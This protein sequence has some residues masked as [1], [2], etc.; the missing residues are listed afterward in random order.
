MKHI[1]KKLIFISLLCL[2]LSLYPSGAWAQID[3]LF[4]FAAPD[5]A[6]IQQGHAD[7]PIYLR[8]ATKA[9][10]TVTVDMP[11]NSSFTPITQNVGAN[12]VGTVDLTP[13][14]DQIETRPFG[15]VLNTG[16]R[17]RSTTPISV[18]YE[19]LA[20][21][22]PPNQNFP[23]NPEIFFLKGRNALGTSFYI[24]SQNF[25]SNSF[26]SNG[27]DVSIVATEDNTVVT[28][29]MRAE[30]VGSPNYQPNQNYSVTLNRGQTF[31]IREVSGNA[32]F[33][34]GGSRI[35]ATKPIAV[36]SSDDS[37]DRNG[38]Q[39]LIGDQIFPVNF[40]GKEYIVP[41]FLPTTGQDRIYVVPTVNNT[42]INLNGVNL[43]IFTAGQMQQIQPSTATS[44]I[45]ANQPIYV[46][47]LTGYPGFGSGIESASAIVPPLE[48]CT[49]TNEVKFFK[50]TATNEDFNVIVLVRDVAKGSFTVNGSTTTLQASDFTI[51]PNTGN[52]WAY[53]IKNLQT[54]APNAN[55]TIANSH[56]QGLFH[57][58]ILN[59]YKNNANNIV[60]ASY[61]FFSNISS[62]DITGILGP[63]R[64]FCDG[65]SVVLD[66]GPGRTSYQWYKDNVL[67]PGATNQTLT[68][69]QAGTYRVDVV[70]AGC[71]SSDEVKLSVTPLP[72]VD[73]GA[74]RTICQGQSTTLDA[75]AGAGR[76]F[77]WFLLPNTTTVI[78]TN[79]TLT[80][81]QAGTYRVEVTQNNCS[82]TDDIVI[83]VQPL[84]TINLGPNQTICPNSSTT[85]DAGAGTG[86]TYKWYRLPNTTDVI[87][88]NRTLT[89]TQAGTYRVEV[90]QNN[91]SNTAEI[92][93]NIDNIPTLEFVE[94]KDSY[95]EN[96]PNFNL[97]ATP[98]G[99]IFRV[100][101]I[102]TNVFS[103]ANLREGVHQV[104]YIFTTPSN[105]TAEIQK[106]VTVLAS[107]STQCIDAEFF[108]P[109]AF[110]PNGDGRS[111]RFIIQGRAADIQTFNLKIFDRF[112]NLVFESNSFTE[113][114]Q[115]GWNGT[116][117]G[118]E[119]PAGVYMWQ[120]NGKTISGADLTF[121][122][123][124]RGN[125]RLIR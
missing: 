21:G 47:H 100:N 125:L 35:T 97:Q 121:K 26:I 42:Q 69:T 45:T 115:T 10:A 65:S 57:L 12:S 116:K 122:N 112:G 29:N 109:E 104:R 34:F 103:P 110:T 30:A 48:G 16:I 13:F 1:H 102:T 8:I 2:C 27:E 119:Q 6:S 62:L 107:T 96:T 39:D 79:A 71:T 90:T 32:S 84:P 73:L 117:D 64:S 58:A 106:S 51:V 99:G 18:Y 108:I 76:T 118:T 44:Y 50:T 81:S 54:L 4:W 63:D 25:M 93:I 123:Q 31:S 74:D 98:A 46:M 38:S 91:C 66:A 28:F 82:N 52:V 101:N 111:D 86:R 78:G 17:I 94:L 37:V 124:T 53:A 43:G 60:G 59:A 92:T 113:M 87:S 23:L 22:N 3:T 55:H 14:I 24:P 89:V 20:L 120:L 9:A 40:C 61:A 95:C 49:G 5:V 68:V 85:L 41:R 75:G 72:T 77:R 7:R 56:P 33:S 105:C 83:T 11:A 15:Q 67:I 80:V 88:T 36:T 19:V 70:Q 114:N